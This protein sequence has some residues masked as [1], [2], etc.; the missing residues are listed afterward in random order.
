MFRL[1]ML[2][3]Y[4]PFCICLSPE[5]VTIPGQGTIAGVEV[6]KLRIQKI[7]AYYGIP[8]AQPPVKKLRFVPPVTNPLPEI[9]NVSSYRS[10]CPQSEEAYK[11]SELPFL[12][13][14]PDYKVVEYSED[15][16]YLNVFVPV[17][18]HPEL[19]FATIIWFHPGNFLIGNPS[20]WNPHTL[21]YRQ[22][23]IVV[24]VAWRLNIFGFFTTMDGE[25]PGNYGLL[26][27]QAAMQWVKNNI[28]LFGGNPDNICLMGYGAGATSIGLHMTNP[29]SVELFNKAIAMSGDYLSPTTI[30]MPEE[31]KA[32]LD[33][34]ARKLDCTRR[35]VSKLLECLR[36]AEVETLLE[37][38][39]KRPWRPLLD[40]SLSNSS[41]QPFLSE[42]PIAYFES[43]GSTKVP[44]L[45][46]Y[47]QM[48][49]ILEIPELNNTQISSE[50]LRSL[51]VKLMQQEL[52]QNN[53][54]ESSCVYN[55]DHIIDAVMFFYGPELASKETDEFRQIVTDFL[56]EKNFAAP[57]YLQAL[58]ISK[59]KP[60]YVYRFDMKPST[61]SAVSQIP[62]WV[63]VS[64]LFDLIYVWGIP[65]W[66]NTGQQWD[67]RDKRI[68]DTIMSLWTNFAKYSDPTANAIFPIKW[69]SFTQ[70]NPGIM[71]IDG[72]FD[73]GNSNNLNYKAFEFW[74]EYYPKIR[75]VATRCCEISDSG[76]T[77]LSKNL[78]SFVIVSLV[79]IYYV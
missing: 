47:T 66:E 60:V 37:I 28:K 9:Q 13:L 20:I 19:G 65:Y 58:H 57:A 22:R 59:E 12:Q 25:A 73:M 71:I 8:Y 41:Y 21:V 68:S 11:E 53:D 44:F 48:E 63:T 31:D 40:A 39:G 49:Q 61:T 18:N 14:I 32:F 46:G 35:P 29:K 34:L 2:C 75:D 64:H 36:Y 7:I 74:N 5:P 26:D 45:T 62:E 17:G 69:Q 24:T 15:C 38:A 10:A 77:N 56:T 1:N 42:P 16:L 67:H 27:Q 43:E 79:V 30:K 51:F 72:N 33:S 78:L 4:V 6:S 76:A 55:P 23:V 52:P 54:T 3:M 70:E 50:A